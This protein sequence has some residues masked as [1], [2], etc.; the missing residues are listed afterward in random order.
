MTPNYPDICPQNL[1]EPWWEENTDDDFRPGRLVWAFLPHVDQVPYTLEPIGRNEPTEHSTAI[2]R[3]KK[4][5]IGAPPKKD[6]L[7]VAAMPLHGKEI[8]CV[9]RTK[10]R[11]AIIISKG[12]A[13]VEKSLTI[14]QPKW[15]T[16]PTVLLAPSY[17]AVGFNEVFA[18]G[19]DVAS[20]HNLCGTTSLL[21]VDRGG[22]LLDLTIFSQSDEVRNPLSLQT[23]ALVTKQ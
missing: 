13:F 16:N 2:Q 12:G 5:Q 6:H 4:Y 19:F 17:S 18:K 15:R 11:P 10:K 9:Y 7:P 20:I 21:A 8:F 14:N 1:I 23:I 22:R 3:I